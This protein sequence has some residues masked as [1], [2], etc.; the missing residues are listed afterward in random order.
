MSKQLSEDTLATYRKATFRISRGKRLKTL[1]DAA[2]FVE[3]RGFITLWPIKGI[4]LPSLWK[5]VAGDRPVASAHD[6]P[7]HITW[8]WKDQMLDK[9]R[10]YYGKLLRGK[11]T[12]VSLEVLPYFYAL[13]E[14]VAE[15]DDYRLAYED[16]RLTHEAYRVAEALFHHGAQNTIQLRRRAQ[17]SSPSSK[18]RFDKAL[19]DLQRGLWLIPIGVAEAGAWRYAF[20]YELFER[21]FPNVAKQARGISPADARSHLT[22]LYLD[23]VGVSTPSAVGK[24]FGWRNADVNAALE[25][26]SE[27]ARAQPLE[28]GRWKSARIRS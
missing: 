18:S 5:A 3:E 11:A 19:T 8:G 10:W 7:G 14:R 4:D 16:G 17:L 1:E 12:I 24:L 27:L 25:R 6:D 28:D 2:A 26:N 13:S 23:S 22:G 9:R 15:L 21:W 20:T